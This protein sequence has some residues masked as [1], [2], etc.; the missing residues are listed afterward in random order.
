MERNL[1]RPWYW[2]ISPNEAYRAIQ[3]GTLSMADFRSWFKREVHKKYSEAYDDGW[4]ER[5]GQS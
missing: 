4:Y 5:D 1:E 2:D 3:D